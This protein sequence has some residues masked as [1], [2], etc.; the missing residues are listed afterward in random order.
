MKFYRLLCAGGGIQIHPLLAP[1]TTIV[2][3]KQT[4]RTGIAT[5]IG[6]RHHSKSQQPA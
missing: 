2:T 6:W 5:P 4:E 3:I 1:T